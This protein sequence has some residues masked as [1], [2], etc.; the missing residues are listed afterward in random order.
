M[1]FS[2][3]MH[4]FFKFLAHV[5]PRINSLALTEDTKTLTYN[6]NAVVV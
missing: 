4:C 6:F 5:S 2:M 1:M 3:Y